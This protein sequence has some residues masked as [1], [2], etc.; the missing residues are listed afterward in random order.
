[1]KRMIKSSESYDSY[2]WPDVDDI[3]TEYSEIS[4][5]I[6]Y[7]RVRTDNHGDILDDS[8]SNATDFG[9]DE[10]E[11]IYD[12]EAYVVVT[13]NDSVKNAFAEFL[14]DTKLD[15]NSTYKV[16]GDF[17]IRY[18]YPLNIRTGR[19]ASDTADNVEYD[20]SGIIFHKLV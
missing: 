15:P 9:S 6:P 20:F 14:F 12:N 11:D 13:D 7:V 4:M 19:A 10:N 18:S 1:M 5:H 8:I 16:D 3:E 17:D 2:L